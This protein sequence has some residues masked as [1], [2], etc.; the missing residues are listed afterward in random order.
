MEYNI[1]SQSGQVKAVIS[2][3]DNSTHENSIMGDN[4]LNMSFTLFEFV[5]LTVNDYVMFEGEKYKLLEPYRPTKKSTIEYEY[6]CKFYGTV[7][8]CK[9]G[10]VLKLVDGE[11]KPDFAL[12]DS[13]AV[14]LQLVVDNINRIKGTLDWTVGEV[15]DNGNHEIVYDSTFCFDALNKIAETFETEWWVEGTTINMSH[16]EFGTQIELGYNQGL[17]DL[18]RDDNDKARFFTRLLPIGSKRNIDPKVYGHN[19]LQLPGGV[20]FVEQNIEYGIVEQ[21]EEQAFAHIY[22]KRIGYV[23]TVRVVPTKIDGK[24]RI[25]YYFTD[26]GLNFDPNDYNIE[27]LVKNVVFQSGELNGRDFEVNFHSNTKEFEIILQYPY[28][29]QQL[30]G[31][32]MIPKTGDKYI[33][34][35]LR[36]PTEYYPLAEQEFTAAAGDFLAKYSIDTSVY[37]AANDYIYFDEN[38]INL[39]V[40]RRIKLLSDEY[41]DSGYSNSRVIRIVRKIWNPSIMDIEFSNA[42]S[43]GRMES[44]EHDVD[45]INVAF[46]EQLNKQAMQVLKSWDSSDPSEYNVLSAIRAITTIQKTAIRKDVAD[47]TKYLVK[48]LAGLQFDGNLSN[49]NCL[50]SMVGYGNALITDP[51]TG[52]AHIWTD[53]I[54]SRQSFETLEMRYRKMI[55]SG[56]ELV[57]NNGGVVESVMAASETILTTA[58]GKQGGAAAALQDIEPIVTQGGD[59]IIWPLAAGQQRLIF[60]VKGEAGIDYQQFV[61]HDIL[62]YTWRDATTGLKGASGYLTV[63]AVV[64]EF[65][66]IADVIEGSPEWL[67]TGMTLALW[68]NLSDPARQGFIVLSARDKTVAI[69]DGVKSTAITAAN[70]KVLLGN[71]SGIVDPAFGS[72]PLS[73]YGL[74]SQHCYLRGN[75]VLRS[76]GRSVED[77]LGAVRNEFNASFEVANDKIESKVS[78]DTYNSYIKQTAKEIALKADQVTIEG[79]LDVNGLI[80]ADKIDT[81]KLI[82]KQIYTTI[83]SNQS[84]YVGGD[85]AGPFGSR[86]NIAGIA[87]NPIYNSGETERNNLQADF[88]LGFQSVGGGILTI[89]KSG[90]WGE[91]IK[92]DRTGYF[93]YLSNVKRTII[94]TSQIRIQSKKNDAFFEAKVDPSF[95]NMDLKLWAKGLP[96][97]SQTGSGISWSALYVNKNTGQIYSE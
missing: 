5:R 96:L 80:R 12:V 13:A 71:L 7:G 41:F 18:A 62:R 24:D 97:K 83:L 90:L 94:S 36:M 1:Y 84:L 75:F 30:P 8:D 92:V 67:Q 34:Y 4:V 52:E 65:T 3:T 54:H 21:A 22:P 61:P 19:R 15:V 28:E 43:K 16:C 78:N 29:D 31:G 25:I 95:D 40:G 70:L 27:G 72:R 82:A 39:K 55:V 69:Y 45:G 74:Y 68:G 47:S 2:P 42:V 59:Y 87:G 79:L 86:V 64:N 58:G 38:N 66:Y 60:T 56:E 93:A 33:L 35:N 44:L 48:F 76:T 85:I 63:Y 9:K 6:N 57:V 51:D 37:K 91:F 73:G 81:D 17:I 50:P 46:K 77:E 14:H 20:Q 89:S 11:N 49:I 88:F 26:T 53:H 32:G 10:I 23:G